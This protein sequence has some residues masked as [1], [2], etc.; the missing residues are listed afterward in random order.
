MNRTHVLVPHW[1]E[2]SETPSCPAVEQGFRKSNELPILGV[3]W[4]RLDVHI[5]EY[6]RMNLFVAR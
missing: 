3:P 4:K 2:L 5:S 1:E 6:A